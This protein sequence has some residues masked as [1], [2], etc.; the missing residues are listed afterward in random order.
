MTRVLMWAALAAV[1]F[2]FAFEAKAGEDAD[3][4]RTGF[5]FGMEPLVRFTADRQTVGVFDPQ[6]GEWITGKLSA[7]VVEE[8]TKRMLGS[9]PVVQTERSVAAVSATKRRWVEVKIPAD[10]VDGVMANWNGP[11]VVIG[12]AD[13]YAF[14]DAKAEW[15]KLEGVVTPASGLDAFTHGQPITHS[16]GSVSVTTPDAVYAF[17]EA[18]GK[19][20]KFDL[21]EADGD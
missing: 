13:V 20:A 19:W 15:V 11:P 2:G 17:S 16:N 8:T 14:S 7:P 18:T 4:P 1:P 3:K 9:R 21:G 6:E 5:V 10:E 12:T